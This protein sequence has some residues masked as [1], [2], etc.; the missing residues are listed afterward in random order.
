[1]LF[2]VANVLEFKISSF[3]ALSFNSFISFASYIGFLKIF[4][5]LLKAAL[6]LHGCEWA[7]S[8]RSKQELLSSCGAWASD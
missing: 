7:S 1:M 3:V 2:N 6:G 8:S 5:Y 4:I